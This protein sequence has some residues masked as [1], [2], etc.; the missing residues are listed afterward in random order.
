M[1]LNKQSIEETA[2]PEGRDGRYG[3]T[4]YGHGL[5]EAAQSRGLATSKVGLA[6]QMG[7]TV[8]NG[9]T[10]YLTAAQAA[11]YLGLKTG[12]LKHHLYRVPVARRLRYSFRIGNN[13]MFSK[14]V[15]DAWNK[16]ARRE[17]GRMAE[18][19]MV[20]TSIDEKLSRYAEITKSLPLLGVIP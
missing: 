8:T 11:R 20:E 18:D 10:Q 6:A 17:E 2:N 12:S 14:D 13:L 4:G 5:I 3:H 15:L 19:E 9:E 1:G 7:K 16:L